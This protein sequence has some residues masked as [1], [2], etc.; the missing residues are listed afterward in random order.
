MAIDFIH[1]NNVRI[2]SPTPLQVLSAIVWFPRDSYAHS[3][4]SAQGNQ[5]HEDE[6]SIL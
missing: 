4:A 3:L 2:I 1:Q 5:Q 6:A